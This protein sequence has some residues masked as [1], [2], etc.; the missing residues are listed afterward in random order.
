MGVGA[1]VFSRA[2]AAPDHVVRPELVDN[3]ETVPVDDF[4]EWRASV[5]VRS[6]DLPSPLQ[7]GGLFYWAPT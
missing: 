7:T 3:I 1:A 2:A 5:L 6:Q 4:V